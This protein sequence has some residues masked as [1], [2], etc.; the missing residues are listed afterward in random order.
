MHFNVI[1]IQLLGNIYTGLGDGRI[2]RVTGE[3]MIT[4]CRTGKE[5]GMIF[6]LTYVLC[7]FIRYRIS[8]VNSM[9]GLF[10]YN[11]W[12]CLNTHSLEEID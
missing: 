1:F 11:L 3:K 4:I 5:C 7:Y 10:L 2:V 9:L 6:F 12:D 8:I